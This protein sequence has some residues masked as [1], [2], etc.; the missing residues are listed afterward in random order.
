MDACG[1][2]S[3]D[4]AASAITAGAEVA[5]MVGEHHAPRSARYGSLVV[6][7]LLTKS[8]NPGNILLLGVP[9]R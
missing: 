7:K 8:T 3:G 5:V 1:S 9:V 2:F 6:M 4:H